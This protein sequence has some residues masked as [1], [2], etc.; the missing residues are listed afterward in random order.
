MTTPD[1][2]DRTTWEMDQ[3]PALAGRLRQ[4]VPGQEFT[5][6]I[7]AMQ[8][9]NTEMTTG[10]AGPGETVQDA[11]RAVTGNVREMVSAAQ[12]TGL[13]IRQPDDRAEFKELQAQETQETTQGQ[14][15]TLR[16]AVDTLAGP[17]YEMKVSSNLRS[18]LRQH[19]G[20]RN[21][22]ILKGPDREP[23]EEFTAALDQAQENGLITGEE[24][25][26]ALLLDV[27]ARANTQNGRTVYA[28]VEISITVNDY[29]VIRAQE[30]ARTISTATGTPTEAV[31]IGARAGER[32]AAMIA[33][34]KARLVRRPAG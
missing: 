28:A 21:A 13:D 14:I 10:Q 25:G 33:D 8:A 29:D 18:L 17:N 34:G 6:A 1:R 30:R 20:L 3:D 4:R 31:V 24:L 2:I 11:I 19:L 26:G 32:A 27:I 23:D 22:R 15:N 7:Q 9:S 12:R 16:E 5:G